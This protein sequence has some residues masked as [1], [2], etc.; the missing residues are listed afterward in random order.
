MS[1]GWYLTTSFGP[2]SPTVANALEAVAWAIRDLLSYCWLKTDAT[3]DRAN[4][5]QVY[6]LSMEFL[7]G[8]SLTSNILN[9]QV[10]PVVKEAIEGEKLDWAEL[11]ETEPDAGLGNGGLGRLAACFLDSMT[12]ESPVIGYGLRY[13]YGRSTNAPHTPHSSALCC[14]CRVILNPSNRTRNTKR[15]STLSEASIV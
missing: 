6:Y 10:D 12:L 2:S 15:L 9:L 4:P 7:I 5:K 13:E 8:R 14:C 11:V 1:G 3:Y